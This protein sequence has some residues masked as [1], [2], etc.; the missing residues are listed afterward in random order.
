MATWSLVLVYVFHPARE[1]IVGAGASGVAVAGEPDLP[2]V[3]VNVG[4]ASAKRDTGADV[5]DLFNVVGVDVV[6]GVDEIGVA[7]A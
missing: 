6:V 3:G 7:V 5:A 1:M 2:G 4:V